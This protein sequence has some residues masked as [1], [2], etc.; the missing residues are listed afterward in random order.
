MRTK[1]GRE[2]HWLR[3][4]NQNSIDVN[5]R[6][7]VHGADSDDKVLHM[8]ALTRGEI[9]SA[10]DGREDLHV[11][12]VSNIEWEQL[13]YF[14][15]VHPSGHL[16]YV[17]LQSPISGELRGIR[18]NRSQRGSKKPRMEMCS[19]CHHVHKTNGT[20]MFTDSVRGSAGRHT[21]GNVICKNLDCSLRIRNMVEPDSYMRET[22]YQPAKIW[23]MQQQMHK[24]L[25]RANQI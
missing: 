8:H 22:L 16:G 4:E 9:V 14:G 23:R 5:R 3:S 6:S 20:A 25:G 19:W 15:W 12:T 11:P 1:S 18:L 13:D 2:K 17:V 10:F 24:W 7:C 21:L